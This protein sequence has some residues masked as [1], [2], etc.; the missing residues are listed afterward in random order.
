MG[1]ALSIAGALV[2][3]GLLILSIGA[4]PEAAY[5]ALLTGSLGGIYPLSETLLRATPLLLA[6]LAVLV[7]FRCGVWNIGAEGQILIAALCVV[8]AGRYLGGLPPILTWALL[9]SLGAAAGA[10]WS[11]LAGVLKL[12][13]HVP[14]VIGTIML[15]FVAFFLVSWA[16]NGP[17]IEA[18]RTQPVS[19]PLPESA[20]LPLL[21]PPTRLHPGVLLPWA[22]AAAVWV[23]LYRTLLGFRLRAVGA[24]PAAARA[25]GVSVGRTL[26]TSFALS[27]ALAGLAG[28]TELLGLF[29]HR[30]SERFLYG[31]GY[32]GIAVALLG[33]LHP[34]GAAASGLFFGALVTGSEAMEQSAGVS[35]VA[36]AVLQA[37]IIFF[38]AA[39]GR[40][41]PWV[42]RAL[43]PES[44]RREDPGIGE[45]DA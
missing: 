8:G 3:G 41:F 19:D 17:L 15:N 28:A 2:A 5:G 22:A 16:V 1:L 42:S 10:G 18:A 21:L 29:P 25:A 33:E 44:A 14:E 12:R 38:L 4:S 45:R 39:R 11:L 40:L 23:L 37:V 35:S 34:F 7:A 20:W 24:N 32:M 31:Y 36:V 6:G 9:L 27:G 43:L 30:L 26:L 13:R